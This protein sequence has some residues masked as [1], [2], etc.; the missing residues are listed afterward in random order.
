MSKLRVKQADGS[1]VDIPIGQG[2]YVFT[3]ADKADIVSQV[4]QSLT[5][6]TWT[7]TLANGSTVTKK[8]VLG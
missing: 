4:K 1:V 6:E 5:T 3:D 2:T 7:F 8:V